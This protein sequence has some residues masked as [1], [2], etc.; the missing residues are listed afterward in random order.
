MLIKSFVIIAFIAII[1]SL[2]SALFHLVKHKED[3][4]STKTAKA[5]NFRIGLSL[6][7]FV[8]IFFIYASGILQP[9]G[10]GAK[11]IEL[12]QSNKPINP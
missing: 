9:N 6:A 8:A 11:I 12:R 2:A 3:S 1:A 7:L 4:V 10:I 5:L